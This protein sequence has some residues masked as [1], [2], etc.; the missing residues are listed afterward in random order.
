MLEAA[1]STGHGNFSRSL[2]MLFQG[3]APR[4]AWQ[5]TSSSRVYTHYTVH[6]AFRLDRFY[7]TTDLMG[8]KKGLETFAAAFTDYFAA[9]L[10]KSV[11]AP[12]VRQ[13]MAHGSGT[14][15]S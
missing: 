10:R 12:I 3:Y 4:V 13:G 15:T 1:G 8:R 14:P 11:N 2:S 5:A 7:L 6:S 9:I